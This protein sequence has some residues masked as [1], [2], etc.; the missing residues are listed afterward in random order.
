MLTDPVSTA[1]QLHCFMGG[2]MK[3]QNACR[4]SGPLKLKTNHHFVTI[5]LNVIAQWMHKISVP[6]LDITKRYKMY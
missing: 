2:S 6:I 4:L 1:V 3:S 5:H